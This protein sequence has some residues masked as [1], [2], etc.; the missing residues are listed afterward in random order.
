MITIN[1]LHCGQFSI[2]F[3]WSK[4]FFFLL[5]FLLK[6]ITVSGKMVSL[7]YMCVMCCL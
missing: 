6:K 1:N 2:S 4:L 5:K 7:I 3:A